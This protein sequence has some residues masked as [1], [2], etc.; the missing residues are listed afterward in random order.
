MERARLWAAGMLDRAFDF[1]EEQTKTDLDGDGVVGAAAGDA[2][3]EAPSPEAADTAEPSP[4]EDP[5]RAAP[6]A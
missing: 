2:A 1:L 6:E 4:T 3:E 5:D